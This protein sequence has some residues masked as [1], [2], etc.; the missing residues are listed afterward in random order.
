MLFQLRLGQMMG[1]FL[2]RLE[3]AKLKKSLKKP[4]GF[5]DLLLFSWS[6]EKRATPLRKINLPSS[7]LQCRFLDHPLCSSDTLLLLKHHVP[8]SQDQPLDRTGETD[9]ESGL[10]TNSEPSPQT[11]TDYCGTNYK[12]LKFIVGSVMVI[13]G[14]FLVLLSILMLTRRLV[15]AWCV[16]TIVASLVAIVLGGLCF[17]TGYNA[18]I[19]PPSHS[20]ARTQAVL[21]WIIFSILDCLIVLLTWLCA[22]GNKRGVINS[23]Y[24]GCYDSCGPAMML[25]IISAVA[26]VPVL[27]VTPMALVVAIHSQKVLSRTP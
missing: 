27:V 2:K 16:L 1:H 8:F 22:S 5:A 6:W 19:R 14:S 23:A 24:S 26:L 17:Y 15:I 18:S 9:E 7:D 10:S 11:S 13:L 4:A 3:K 25:V 12:V 20:E 21:F